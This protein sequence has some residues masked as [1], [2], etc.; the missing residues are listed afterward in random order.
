MLLHLDGAHC[1]GY[2]SECGTNVVVPANVK[3]PQ[4]ILQAA[5]ETA[6]KNIDREI[7]LQN[8]I[9]KKA[10]ESETEKRKAVL[11]EFVSGVTYSIWLDQQGPTYIN[12]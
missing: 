8:K 9:G 6:K 4:F 11:S 3:F 2:Y 12:G 5:M 7:E 10:S 1:R